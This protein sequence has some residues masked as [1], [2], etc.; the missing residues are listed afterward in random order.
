MNYKAFSCIVV[1]LILSGCAA[2]QEPVSTREQ[3]RLITLDDYKKLEIK[4]CKEEI[5]EVDYTKEGIY[6]PSIDTRRN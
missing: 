5:I 1:F 2:Q 3:K 6:R 4:P